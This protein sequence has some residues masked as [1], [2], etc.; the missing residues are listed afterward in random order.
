MLTDIIIS[1]ITFIATLTGLGIAVWSYLDTRRKFSHKEFIEDREQQ[2]KK[3][4]K[5]F[6]E[7]TRLGKK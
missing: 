3:A 5:R 7:R 2:R 6:K 4:E 1:G